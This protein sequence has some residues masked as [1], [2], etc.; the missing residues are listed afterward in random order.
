MVLV[1][2]TR[3]TQLDGQTLVAATIPHQ[4]IAFPLA[5][6]MKNKNYVFLILTILFSY[7]SE[8]YACNCPIVKNL[9]AI[10][11]HEYDNSNR[12]FIGEVLAFDR[13]NECF[14]VKI[15]EA[16]KGVKV[17]EIH[18]GSYDSQCGPSVEEYGIWLIYG[19]IGSQEKIYVNSCGI[20]RSF[21][22][23]E[24]NISIPLNMRPM[25]GGKDYEI[26]AAESNKKAIVVLRNEI[27]ELRKKNK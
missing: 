16:F 17:G 20:S 26:W 22:K 1:A 6:S 24:Y 7:T 4:I 15:V 25:P 19:F 18:E 11:E 5:T 27:E 2:S 21:A 8:S 12:V 13:E 9:K 23:P 10:Q 14:T 3:K